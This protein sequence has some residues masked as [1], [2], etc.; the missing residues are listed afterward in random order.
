MT[1]LKNCFTI[2]YQYLFPFLSTNH[3]QIELIQWQ[4][5]PL[6]SA[7][8]QLMKNTYHRQKIECSYNIIE[9]YKI[10]NQQRNK[11]CSP[12]RTIHN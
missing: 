7:S 3:Y 12:K 2:S 8:N 11:T 5:H 10:T 1:T 4:F 6:I 9:R